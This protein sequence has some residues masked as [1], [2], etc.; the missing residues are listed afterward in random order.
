MKQL[1]V[2]GAGKI[3]EVVSHHLLHDG[4]R[5]ISAFTCEGRYVPEAGAFC[6]RP[7]VPFERIEK[8]YPPDRFEMIVAVGYQELNAARRRICEQARAK[9][10]R[11]ASFVS[12]RAAYGDWLQIG[13]NCL[14]LDDV[15][16]EPRV[17]IGNNVVLWSGVLV[18]HHSVLEDD[19]WVAG[20]AVFG[21]SSKLGAGSFVGLGA[22]VGPE[23]EIGAQSFL[24]AG[25]VV[26]KC[27]QPKS[28]FIAA[29][30]QEYRLDS[31]HFMQISK[32]H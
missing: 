12:R 6:G 28:V 31:D 26:T 3:G 18:G 30:T 15:I 25:V 8:D 32:F 9:G 22:V 27:A 20:R 14:I 19:C 24:G 1:V 23:V 16:I 29:D 7:V 21:G 4:E 5:Q 13:D 10:Y 11:L 17:L 2:F